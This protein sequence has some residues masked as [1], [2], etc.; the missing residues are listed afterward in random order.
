M[1]RR[2]VVPRIAALIEEEEAILTNQAQFESQ[3]QQLAILQFD[4]MS[5][6]EVFLKCLGNHRK[7]EVPHHLPQMQYRGVP[8]VV[9]RS[10]KESSADGYA[11]SSNQLTS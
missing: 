10:I 1:S 3:L 11:H 2:E 9:D 6:L 5:F 7:A 4:Q 8:R